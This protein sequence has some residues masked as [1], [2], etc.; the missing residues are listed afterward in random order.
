[1]QPE[2]PVPVPLQPKKV[3]MRLGRSAARSASF[4]SLTASGDTRAT[5]AASVETYDE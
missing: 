5:C 3:R 2:H 1:M 4:V